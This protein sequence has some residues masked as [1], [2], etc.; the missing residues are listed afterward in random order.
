MR[1]TER[2][3]K[4]IIRR[5][6]SEASGIERLDEFKAIKDALTQIFKAFGALLFSGFSSAKSTYDPSRFKVN[7]NNPGAGRSADK[8]EPKK[9][10]VSEL[11]QKPML[12]STT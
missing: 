2:Q 8:L 5:E 12:F 7:Y 1:L 11:K 6:L 4:D 10:K 3:I 9:L